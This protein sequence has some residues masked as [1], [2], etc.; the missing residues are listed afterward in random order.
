MNV[1]NLKLLGSMLDKENP[2]CQ[3]LENTELD[4]KKEESMVIYLERLTGVEFTKMEKYSHYDSKE[5]NWLFR[6]T[7]GQKKI[8]VSMKT[9]ILWS[10][11][12]NK[13]PKSWRKILKGQ[14]AFSG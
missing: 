14:L 5:F 4:K 3:V 12:H 6:V 11:K 8:P 1:E 10:A 2:L 7:Y 9:R 13:V